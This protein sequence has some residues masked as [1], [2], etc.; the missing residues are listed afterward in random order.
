LKWC[1]DRAPVQFLT[2]TW[3]LVDRPRLRAKACVE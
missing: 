2:E 3:R 1:K